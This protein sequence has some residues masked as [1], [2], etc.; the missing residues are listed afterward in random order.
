LTF[1]RHIGYND[2]MLKI[3]AQDGSLLLEIPVPF[4]VKDGVTLVESQAYQG[5]GGWLDNFSRVSVCAPVVPEYLVD[6]TMSWTPVTDLVE[7][8][9]LSVHLLPWGYHPRAHFRAVGAVRATFRE[10]IPT[11]QHLCF[12]NLGVFG[13]WGSVA[14]QEAF[15]LDRPYS[16]WLDWVL[17]EMPQ[18]TQTNPLKSVW[19]KVSLAL[20]KRAVF[21]DIRRSAVGLFNG[22]SVYQAYSPLCRVPKLV[23]DIHLREKDIIPQAQLDARLDREPTTVNVLYVGRVHEMKG[24]VYWLDCLEKVITSKA[25]GNLEVSATWLGD[26][27]LLEEMRRL[28]RERGLEKWIAF[29]GSQ[30]D[31]N[32]VVSIYREADLF[33]FCHVTPES[34]RNL[35]EALMSGLPIL[36]FD[37]AY[38]RDLIR[39]GGGV[40]APMKDSAALA[41]VVA[42]YAKDAAARHALSQAALRTGKEFSEEVVFTRRSS[43][44]KEFA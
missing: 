22:S 16:I 3:Q 6:A 23:H 10:L 36:G 29:P 7:R 34:P 37:S 26:G 1:A 19:Q 44:I 18:P 11:H 9:G 8:R 25:L 27:P 35:V 5:L 20:L 41:E 31:R 15:K 30:A 17:H 43:Y 24:P 40:T 32:I 38:A 33:V 21:R 42:T 39:H 12:A 2:A 4:R 28:V 13:A 14:A